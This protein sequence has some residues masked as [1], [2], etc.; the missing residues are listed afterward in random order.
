MD[1]SARVERLG[2]EKIGKLLWEMSSQTTLSLLVYAIYSVTDTYFLSVGIN[3]LAAAGASIISPVLIALGGVATT[4]GAGGAS[5]VS[6][7]LGE[8]QTER[9]SRT[10]ANTF[11]IFWTVAIVITVFGA[12]FIG[13]IVSMLGATDSIAPYAITYGRIIFLGAI[14]STGY[15]TIVRAD[16]NIRYSTAMWMIP[17]SANVVFCWLFIIV[18]HT[19]VAGAALATVIGQ[20]ISASMSVYFFFFKKNRSYRIKAAYFKP[21]WS[22]M[23]EV[24]IIGFPSF[25]KSISAS[26]VVIV[27]NNLLKVIGGDSAL[28]VFAIVNRLYAGL[29][30]PQTGIMQG[31]QPILGYNFGQK[32]FGRVRKTIGYSLGTAIVYGLIVCGLCLL[33]PAT[34][35]ALLSKETRIITEGQVALRL[36]SLAC[37]LSGV[38]LMV[39][40]YF[41]AVGRAKEALLLTLGGIILIKLP[42]LL[43]ASSLFSLT[44]IWSAEAASEGLLCIISLLMLR[45][46][47]VKM[48]AEYRQQEKRIP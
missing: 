33:I 32:R 21:D 4:V 17:V 39:A 1:S 45:R 22:I 46:Y 5:V 23:A 3:S 24:I 48:T 47:Q 7:A 13:P 25:F 11:L 31:M 28:G 20:A 12:L 29:N 19:G 16:G 42:V 6:R 15:S 30:T 10:V 14:T 34:L 43:L 18:L 26:L 36:M 2:M 38:S 44:G 27:T 8:A 35:I 37:P 40:A 41:Q 9:A